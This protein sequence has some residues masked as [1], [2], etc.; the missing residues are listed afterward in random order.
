MPK[1]IKIEYKGIKTTNFKNLIIF[2]AEN[3]VLLLTKNTWEGVYCRGE[4]IPKRG[5]RSESDMCVVQAWHAV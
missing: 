2:L 4:L 3:L 1:K 5:R